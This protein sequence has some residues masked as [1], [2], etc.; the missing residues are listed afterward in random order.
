MN[1]VLGLAAVFVFGVG[2]WCSSPTPSEPTEFPGTMALPIGPWPLTGARPGGVS[3]SSL[4]DPPAAL[5]TF[6]LPDSEGDLAAQIARGTQVFQRA[7]LLHVDGGTPDAAWADAA[8]T[9]KADRG[10]LP[11]LLRQPLQKLVF[12]GTRLSQLSALIATAGPAHVT[13]AS[14]TLQADTALTITG[15]NV[16]VD[17]SGAAIE[18]GATAPVWLVRLDH[19]RDVAL[20]NAKVT[21]GTNGFLVDSGSNIALDGNDVGGLTE[22]GIV[23]SGRSS[24]LDIH[25]NHLHDLD[26]AAIMLDGPV[27]TA[28]LADN[29]IDHLRGHSNWNAGILLT[30]RGGDIA[31]DP[32]TFFLPDRY[33]VVTEPLVR[34]LQNPEQNVITDNTIRDGLSSGVYDDGAVANVFVGNRIEGNSKEGICFDNGA[35]A[36]VFAGNLVAANGKRWGQPDTDLAFDSVLGAGRGV[37]GTS[38]AKLP[39]IS[40]DNALFN[41]IFANDVIGNFGGG[42]KMVRT[43]LFNIVGENVIADNNLGESAQFHFFGIELGAAAADKPAA[44]LN[45]VGSSGNIAFAN[46]I[47]GKHYAGIYFGSDSVQN[48]VVDNEIFGAEVFAIEAPAQAVELSS[49]IRDPNGH[50]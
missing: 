15:Q 20:I 13:V 22:N 21:S 48:D 31:A 24:N 34:R 35:T 39:G 5:Y 1:K 36:N 47:R 19:A 25:A 2:V 6:D 45:F 42:V 10:I 38:L 14:R 12:N 50:R 3:G 32:D 40:M 49:G 11:G 46:T 28:W 30:S 17:F 29:E 4:A 23:V 43:G 18:V 7:Q 9:V 16:T 44:D 41:E 8:D 27:E 26:R 37:D 33:W